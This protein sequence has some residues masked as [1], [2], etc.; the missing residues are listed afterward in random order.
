M[1]RVLTGEEFFFSSPQLQYRL[2][3]PSNISN[4]YWGFISP[5]VKQ[6]KLEAKHS[7]PPNAEVKEWRVRKVINKAK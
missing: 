4:G 5:G 1:V 2:W 3:G 7:I 6:P